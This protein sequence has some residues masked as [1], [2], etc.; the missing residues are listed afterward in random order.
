MDRRALEFVAPHCDVRE[1]LRDVPGTALV[2]GVFFRPIASVLDEAGELSSYS[3][4]FGSL[5]HYH[6]LTFYPLTDYLVRLASAGAVLR[7]PAELMRGVA[8]IS[9]QNA[10]EFAASLLGKAL[11]EELAND[12]L[13]LLEQGLAMRRQTANYGRWELVRHGP[14]EL[15]VRYTDE[16]IWIQE[17]LTAAATGTFD[18][19]SIKP[20][21]TTT[22]RDP[23]NGTTHFCW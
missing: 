16:Y 9:R 3:E 13:R 15:E 23:Y 21:V 2:R 14:R 19:C 17:A 18:A 22:L 20:T 5:Q 10:R 7:S 1:R 6:S 11:I 12:P 8:D 4:R